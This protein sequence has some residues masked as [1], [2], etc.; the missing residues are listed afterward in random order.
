VLAVWAMTLVSLLYWSKALAEQL[1]P[2]TSHTV[3]HTFAFGTLPMP[4]CRALLPL[5]GV[6][7]SDTP[8]CSQLAWDTPACSHLDVLD[9]QLLHDA[10]WVHA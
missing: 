8:A 5:H 9:A 10:R 7:A 6:K 2:S 4:S 3:L 1:R